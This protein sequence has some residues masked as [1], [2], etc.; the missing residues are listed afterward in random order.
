MIPVS[1][2]FQKVIGKNMGIK[3]LPKKLKINFIK[4]SVVVFLILLLWG[5]AESQL[6]FITYCK[7]LQEHSTVT[8][9]V[10]D[11]TI[12]KSNVELNVGKNQISRN[13][14]EIV[15]GYCV[16][17]E[18]YVKNK[19]TKIESI[20]WYKVPP[21]T[22]QS[23]TEDKRIEVVFIAKNPGS[24]VPEIIYRKYLGDL[25]GRILLCIVGALIV[26]SITNFILYA[27][28]KK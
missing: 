11:T 28:R 1:T 22:W 9:A 19:F 4:V 7:L 3:T 6:K 25:V 8:A 18:F 16:K 26:S 21:D 12:D 14:V 17:Y 23:A 10:T 5:E 24:N 2:I 13:Q 20:K 15:N 27:G